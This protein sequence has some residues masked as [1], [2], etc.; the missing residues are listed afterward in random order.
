MRKNKKTMENKHKEFKPFDRVIY[1][2]TYSNPTTWHCGI[3]SDYNEQN[4][5]ITLCSGFAFLLANYE[6]LPY[7]GNEAL[8]GT[9]DDP[10]GEIKLEEGEYIMVADEVNTSQY[11][12]VLKNFAKIHD[13]HDC[14]RAHALDGNEYNW[15]YAVR[16]SDF[17][18]SDMEETRKHILCVRNGRIVK[19]KG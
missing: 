1:R 13:S 5:H 16:F 10:E 2:L 9:T 15:A 6:V 3:F 8:V 4:N 18:P 17:N 11:R 19:Y 7:E 14:F 12:W